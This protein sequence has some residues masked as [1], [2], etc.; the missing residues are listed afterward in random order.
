VGD[1]GE[2]ATSFGS[3]A[4]S[5]DRV[6]PG[7]APAA[8]DWLLPADCAV[9]VDLAAGTGLFTRALEGRAGQVVAVEPDE[10]M[11]QVLAARSPD[12]RVLDGRAEDIPLP[13]GS[14]DAVFVSHAWHWFDPERAVPEIARVLRDGGRFGVL[15]T[16]RDHG[17]AWVAELEVIQPRKPRTP[18]ESRER[19]SRRHTVTMPEGAPFTAT[20]ALSFGFSRTISVDDTLDWLATASQVITADPA[21][22]AAGLARSRAALETRSVQAAGTDMVSMPMRSWCWRADRLPRIR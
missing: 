15:W 14:A 17:V 4:G 11:R 1:R 2:A 8:V 7:P 5:Y 16:S 22:R 6:R 21:E 13:D 12:V 19:Q 10:R 20:E 9:A 3:V 18:D